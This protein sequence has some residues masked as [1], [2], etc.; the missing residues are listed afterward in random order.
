MKKR[1]SSVICMILA[2]AIAAFCLGCKTPLEKREA[3]LSELRDE[4]MIA[5]TERATITLCSGKREN[6]FEIDGKSSEKIDFTVLTAV[7][8]DLDEDAEVSY[9]LVADGKT[10]EGAL[11][12]HPFK[13]SYSVELGDRVTGEATATVT[14]GEYSETVELKTVLTG[15]EITADEALKIAEKRLKVRIDEMTDG[16]ALNA[17][18]YVRY[19]ENPISSAGGYYW[20]VAFCPQKYEVYAVLIDPLT[21]EITAV[22]E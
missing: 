22:R 11:S 14:S 2:V 17:E 1:I 6:P 4:F 12:K 20:Y 13:N 18:I 19:I 15:E 10:F 3:E 5:K 7:I 16:N 9:K 8:T 21:R